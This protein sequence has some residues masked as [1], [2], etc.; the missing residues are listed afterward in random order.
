MSSKYDF[1]N[2]YEEKG[3][4]AVIGIVLFVLALAF[5]II[6]LE[7]WVVMALWNACL[8]P[9]VTVLNEVGFWQMWGIMVVCNSL[10]KGWI[11]WGKKK[12]N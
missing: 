5:G 9:A 12:D 8:V 6:C 3:C 7:A 4:A 10:F 1:D 2:V 11:H